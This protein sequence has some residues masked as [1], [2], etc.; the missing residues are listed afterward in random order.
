MRT[1]SVS[2]LTR[3]GVEVSYIR[4]AKFPIKL[5]MDVDIYILTS[6]IRLTAV[7]ALSSHLALKVFIAVAI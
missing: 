2:E 1:Y 6:I 5:H 4:D 3:R 7:L